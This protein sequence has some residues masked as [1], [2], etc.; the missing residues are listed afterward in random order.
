LSDAIFRGYYKV[1]RGYFISRRRKIVEVLE[2]DDFDNDFICATLG[3]FDT[4]IVPGTV[5]M[6]VRDALYVGVGE[7]GAGFRFKGV[8]HELVGDGIVIG[9]TP[10]GLPTSARVAPAAIKRLVS[11]G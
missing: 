4:M 3:C 9:H 5:G 11:F 1:M 8:R 6:G 7:V 2:T 10:D